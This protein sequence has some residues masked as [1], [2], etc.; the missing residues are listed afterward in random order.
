LEFDGTSQL[1]FLVLDV[2]VSNPLEKDQTL[3][4]ERHRW[5]WVD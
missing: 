3:G 1:D 4:R 5:G 2:I